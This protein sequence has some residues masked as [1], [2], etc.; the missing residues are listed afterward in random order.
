[1]VL[2]I[3]N[4]EHDIALGK[5][6]D[7]FTP[8]KAARL[9]RLTFG[10]CPAF[11]AEDGDWVLVD[12][13]N[14]AESNLAKESRAHGKVRFVTFDELKTLT[15][16]NLPERIE[17]W[18]WDR[19]LVRQLVRCNPLFASLV[20][21]QDRL[22]LIRRLSSRQFVAETILP[23]MLGRSQ[24]YIGEM[25]VC[26]SMDEIMAELMKNNGFIVLKSPWSCSGRGVRF[27]RER[28]SESESGWI[29][30]IFEEQGCIIA[31][32]TFDKVID[33]AMEFRIDNDGRLLKTGLNVFETNNGAY[34]R[35][36]GADEKERTA[37]LEKHIPADLLEKLQSD[38]M[39]VL[40][41]CLADRYIG[42]LGI[43][44]MIVRTEENKT[45]VHPCVEM[46]LRRTMGQ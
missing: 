25:T 26:H 28:L 41:D 13:I 46:N 29:R 44:M 36:L 12:D 9:T 39:A 5:N 32:P 21:D 8:P 11:W 37:I 33:F 24:K 22:A 19:L 34:I 14:V 38:I 7:S 6:S 17:P 31:E 1:M 20:P 18:G 42:P 23:A 16:D 3:Y 4:P 40:D 15:P 43:D 45:K 35:N 30:N 2:H 27:V 10:H